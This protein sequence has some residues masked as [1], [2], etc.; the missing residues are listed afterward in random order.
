MLTMC[1][2]TAMVMQTLVCILNPQIPE[3][4]VPD[5]WCYINPR[6]MFG[7]E[8]LLASADVQRKK[9]KEK[10]NILKV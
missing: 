7:T 8:H 3:L 2:Q 10:K 4:S 1:I 9:K 5:A 6:V